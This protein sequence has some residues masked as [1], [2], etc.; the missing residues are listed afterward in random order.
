MHVVSKDPAS[1]PRTRKQ[2]N[3]GKADVL[4]STAARGKAGNELAVGVPCGIRARP[5]SSR[6]GEWNPVRDQGYAITGESTGA[7]IVQHANPRADAVSFR[8]EGEETRP[9]PSLEILRHYREQAMDNLRLTIPALVLFS[10]FGSVAVAH[11]GGGRG[12]G[13][14]HG[15][16]PSAVHGPATGSPNAGGSKSVA[17][18]PGANAAGASQNGSTSQ[19]TPAAI[20]SRP[21]HGGA[22]MANDPTGSHPMHKAH[23]GS[24][25]HTNTPDRTVPR[26]PSDCID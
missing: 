10:V 11:G 9:L 16:A 14:S 20:G 7:S 1:L 12:G 13:G 26:G 19:A 24:C 6:A 22:K 2:C 25:P 8:A 5:A 3:Q 18:A 17:A 21:E 4:L 15:A 23:M